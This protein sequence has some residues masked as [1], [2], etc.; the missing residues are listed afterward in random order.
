MPATDPV[1]AILAS[2]LHLRHTPP[3]CRTKEPDWYAAQQ[4]PLEEIRNLR[5]VYDCPVVWAGDIFHKWNP[6]NEL[7]NFALEWVDGYGVPGQHDLPHH[8][9]EDMYKSAF[10]TLCMAGRITYLPPG[11]LCQWR[12]EWYMRGFQWGTPLQPFGPR[13]PQTKLLAVV[14]RFC[15]IPEKGYPEAAATDLAAAHGK[16]LEGYSTAVFGDNHKGFLTTFGKGTA[17]MLNCGS[18]MRTT[19]AQENYAPHVGLLYESGRITQ[20]FLDT[21][22]D[23]FERVEGS[24][25][26]EQAAEALRM[27]EFLAALGTLDREN[28]DFVA[29]AR[30]AVER[31]SISARARTII[32]E[33]LGF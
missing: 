18:V 33:I 1:I 5:L 11:K 2:D 3:I 27:P 19:S 20:H 26:Y 12:P 22:K 25:D 7:V 24:E 17:N 10:W 4:R 32:M 29:M 16:A 21:S 15:W 13:P 31:L 30:E 9:A 6:P 23:V 28:H 8:N 14:H